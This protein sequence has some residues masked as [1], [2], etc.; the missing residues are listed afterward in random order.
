M[1]AHA[2]GGARCAAGDGGWTGRHRGQRGPTR[3]A[4]TGPRRHG[5]LQHSAPAVQS[6]LHPQPTGAGCSLCDRIDKG[7]L[8]TCGLCQ[9]VTHVTCYYRA[10]SDDAVYSSHQTTDWRCQS[11]TGPRRHA[12]SEGRHPSRPHF[13]IRSGDK[14]PVQCFRCRHQGEHDDMLVCE[15]TTCTTAAH[16]H[17]YFVRGSVEAEDWEGDMGLWTCHL[18]SGNPIPAL[19]HTSRTVRTWTRARA[20]RARTPSQPQQCKTSVRLAYTAAVR[21]GVGTKSLRR[22][23]AIRRNMLQSCKKRAARAWRRDMGQA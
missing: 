12:D 9:L 6:A 23:V 8:L 4:C 13:A 18:C 11:C 16:L 1:P 10:G 5:S 15:T 3:D 17:C 14:P 2:A 19:A 20:W 22:L 7:P 21:S